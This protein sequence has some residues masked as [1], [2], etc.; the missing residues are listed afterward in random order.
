MSVFGEDG[1]DEERNR[2]LPIE[3]HAIPFFLPS[4]LCLFSS[5]FLSR[6]DDGFSELA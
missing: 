1:G 5:S 3:P 2:K 4:L 6:V